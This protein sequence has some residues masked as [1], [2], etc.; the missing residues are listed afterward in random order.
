MKDLQEDCK[1]LKQQNRQ[2]TEDRENA[3]AWNQGFHMR[4]TRMLREAAAGKDSLQA[5]LETLKVNRAQ[6]D[7][8]YVNCCTYYW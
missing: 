8:R 4:G 3:R 7:F 5:E 2:L 6:M 1:R